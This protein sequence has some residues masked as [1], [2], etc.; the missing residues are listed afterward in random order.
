MVEGVEDDPQAV[1]PLLHPMAGR[2]G[3]AKVEWTGAPFRWSHL[4]GDGAHSFL[5]GDGGYNAGHI[6]HENELIAG[7]KHCLKTQNDW[8]NAAINEAGRK[9]TRVETAPD[10]LLDLV[11]G[12]LEDV[13]GVQF[14]DLPEQP[15]HL[16]P[17]APVVVT[18]SFIRADTCH[19]TLPKGPY[20]TSTVAE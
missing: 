17:H 12:V 19:P 16:R 14:V 7:K 15:V 10:G 1:L 11:E 9:I 18:T 4:A 5:P 2:E 13:V 8:K 6:L 20:R 3:P